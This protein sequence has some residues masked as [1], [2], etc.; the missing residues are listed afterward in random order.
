MQNAEK[1]VSYQWSLTANVRTP[2]RIIFQYL[3]WPLK[4]H[5]MYSPFIKYSDPFTYSTLYC[6]VHLI[7]N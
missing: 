3:Q 6:V 7:L 5:I 2:G 4:I 1:A